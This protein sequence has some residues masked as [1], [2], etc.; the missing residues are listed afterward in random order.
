MAPANTKTVKVKAH[1]RVVKAK[2]PAK[3]RVVKAKAPAKPRVVK[4]KAP[5]KPRVVKAKAPAKPRVVK[6]KAPAKPRAR[7]E[8][9]NKFMVLT[10]AMDTIQ[11]SHRASAGG[12][13]ASG[14]GELLYDTSLLSRPA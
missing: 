13:S 1:T 9:T 5:A 14:G 7:K 11:K 3:P 12:A 6:A 4:A 2:A 8:K 10:A